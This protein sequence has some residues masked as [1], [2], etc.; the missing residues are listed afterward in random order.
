MVKSLTNPFLG[1]PT[2][3]GSLLTAAGQRL[4][5]ELDA[6]LRAAGFADLRSAHASIFMSIDPEGSRVTE[7]ARRTRM[8]K[9]AVGEL[10]RYL[11]GRG[12]LAVEP[13]PDD[14]RAKRVRLTERGWEAISLGEQ[15]I[16]QFDQWL[17]T[18]FGAAE[19]ARLRQVLTRIAETGPTTH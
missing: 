11:C 2:P 9:Q 3:M 4:A 18:T 17:D 15:V 5:G 8:T 7:L 14:R 12:Y 1:A 13:D 19:I 6:S 16:A 10:I